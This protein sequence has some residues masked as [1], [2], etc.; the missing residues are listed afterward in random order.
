MFY[1]ANHEY[2][3][4]LSGRNLAKAREAVAEHLEYARLTALAALT[5][6]VTEVKVAELVG[7]DRMT[8]RKWA[9]KR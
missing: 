6:G 5:D 1:M 8:V 9:G 4:G 2:E 3:L 7:V